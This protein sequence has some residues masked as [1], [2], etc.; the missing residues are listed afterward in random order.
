MRRRCVGAALAVLL[1]VAGSGCS[2][3][4]GS[5]SA[6]T[7]V[8][9]A[10]CP[11]TDDPPVV[12]D[13]IA[14]A[15]AAVEAERGGPQR[16]FEINASD[17]LVNLLVASADGSEVIPYVFIDGALTSTDPSAAEGNTFS[18]SAVAFDA[19][20]VTS[21][22]GRDLASSTIQAFVILG[23]P[24]DAVQYTL[25]TASAQGGQLVIEIDRDGQVLTVDPV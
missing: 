25:V 17:L 20:R 12:V 22:V 16:F 24:N 7:V 18:G 14:D 19:E 10:D 13:Q 21:C 5:S 11:A 2:D 4:A 9:G 1:G 3:D 8:L 6:T 15:I 23:G